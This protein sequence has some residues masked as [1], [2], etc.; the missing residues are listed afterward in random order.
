MII[1]DLDIVVGEYK[2]RISYLENIDQPRPVCVAKRRRDPFDGMAFGDEMNPALAD[3][4]GDGDFDLAVGDVAG[5]VSH[6]ENV[7][8]NDPVRR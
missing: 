2:A 7:G 5:L 6:Y 8:S 1:G 3:L 4:D